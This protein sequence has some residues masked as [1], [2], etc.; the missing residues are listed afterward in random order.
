M[1]FSKYIFRSHM[2]GKIIN[3]PKPLS[4]SSLK[5]LND[6]IL[7]HKGEG[8]PLTEKQKETLIDLQYKEIQSKK[9]KLSDASKRELSKIVYATQYGRTTELNSNQITKGL[10]VEKECR[11]ILSRVT[12]LFLTSSEERKS[13]KW[14]TGKIDIEP[15]EVISDI[16]ATY[17]WES[18]SKILESSANEI[19]LRQGD[20]YMDLWGRDNFLLCHI[21]TDTPFNIIDREIKSLDYKHNI[22]NIEGDVR[23][24]NIDDVKK[25]ITNH[26]FSRKSLEEYCQESSIIYIEWFN[27]FVEIPEKE[28]IHMIPHSFDKERIE[29]RNEC[30]SLARE[31]MST[32][33]PINNFNEKL[34]Y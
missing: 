8:R 33:K 11:D 18:F 22:L 7:R 25:V 21:L 24:S 9:Y 10:E 3:V 23:D 19:Y 28:R 31:Y 2:V 6:Y 14:V 17:S 4:Q 13:N 1:D 34:I 29:Q 20:S 5:M 12:G 26:I 15:N 27:D 16:K 30:I 32:V